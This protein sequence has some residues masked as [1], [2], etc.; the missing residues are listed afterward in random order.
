MNK[1][2]A[3]ETALSQREKAYGKATTIKLYGI[4]DQSIE[5]VSSSSLGLDIA[6][7]IGGYQEGRVIETYGPESSGKTA[8]ILHTIAEYQKKSRT[9]IFID[10]EHAF[11]RSYTEKLGVDI[12]RLI[13]SQLDSGEQA[14]EITDTS[15]RSGSWYIYKN[16]KI[17]QSKKNAEIFLKENSEIAQEIKN[18]ILMI[19]DLSSEKLDEISI[20]NAD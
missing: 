20:S 1:K 12:D 7:G 15:I 18:K 4:D 2:K 9:C 19:K 17:G 14:V 6:L 13:L 3:L 16:Q 10:T 11:D 8:L 5:S